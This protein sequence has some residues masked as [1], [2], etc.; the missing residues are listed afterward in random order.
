[1]IEISGK[2]ITL[3]TMTQKELRALWRKYTPA[4]DS[5]EIEY[6]Y[7]EADVDLRYE[8]LVEK[9]EWNPTVGIFT[10]ND[11]IVGE[12]TFQRI[13][14]SEKRCE[15]SIM[16]ANGTYRNKG[17]GTEA[18]LLAKSYAKEKL[19]LKKMYAEVPESNEIMQKTLK[20]CGFQHIKTLPDGILLFYAML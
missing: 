1:M 4:P 17:M 12:L 13:V 16:I 20:K 6:Q 2:N 15:L 10:R 11:E 18:I 19:G 14:F 9:D 7:N 8:Q 3:R 5:V